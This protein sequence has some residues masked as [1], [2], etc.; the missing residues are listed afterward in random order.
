VLTE[1]GYLFSFGNEKNGRLGRASE[2]QKEEQKSSEVN[3]IIS[4]S[5]NGE[6]SLSIL[7]KQKKS[8]L[9]TVSFNFIINFFKL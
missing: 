4:R 3:P 5:K 8:W 9:A 2:L 1:D 6:A 7:E